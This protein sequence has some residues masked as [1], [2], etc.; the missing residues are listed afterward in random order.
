[1]GRI[2]QSK[3]TKLAKGSRCYLHLD[4]NCQS[5]GETTVFAHLGGAGMGMKNR[6]GGIDFGCPAC[7]NCHSR[8]DFRVQSDPP[9]DREWVELKHLRGTIAY[10][11]LMA[12]EGIIECK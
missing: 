3:M 4:E 5:G 9:L 10:M 12:K 2:K 11:S 1:V 6:A 8:A 7:F